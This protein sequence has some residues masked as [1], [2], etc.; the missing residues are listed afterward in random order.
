M[1]ILKLLRR[2]T[3]QNKISLEN[4][5]WDNSDS[6]K[7]SINN[8]ICEN[9][10]IE[11]F[12]LSKN[13]EENYKHSKDNNLSLNKNSEKSVD[14]K[15]SVKY[16]TVIQTESMIESNDNP[17]LSFSSKTHNLSF[18]ANKDYENENL[19][20][21]EFNVFANDQTATSSLAEMFMSKKHN[22]MKSIND[23]EWEK[24]SKQPKVQK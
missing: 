9:K 18:K 16:V 2:I 4:H 15:E 10:A 21:E 14:L 8:E 6:L 11:S 19:K 12:D 23:R 1:I 5:N 7:L 17:V 13:Q 24:I 20:S 22:I 3:I